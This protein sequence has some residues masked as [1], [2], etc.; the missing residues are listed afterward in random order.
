[1]GIKG[2]WLTALAGWSTLRVSPA[3]AQTFW[4]AMV[5]L[6]ASSFV[7][8]ILVSLLTRRGPTAS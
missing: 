2:G 3:M 8:T 4:M 7:V 6:E 1:M 5:A